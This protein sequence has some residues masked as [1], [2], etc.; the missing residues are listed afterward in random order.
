MLECALAAFVTLVYV[1]SVEH[2]AG[3]CAQHYRQ[4]KH[5]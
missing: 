5:V 2:A 3:E 1:P 4:L